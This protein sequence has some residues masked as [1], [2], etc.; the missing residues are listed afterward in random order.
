M[1]Y[2]NLQILPG[3]T[4]PQKRALVRDFTRTLVQRL[5]KRPEHI[6][7]VIQEIAPDSW[8]YA[9]QLT[10]EPARAGKKERS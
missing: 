3:A 2:L 6:H 8:G 4:V 5:G 9:G 7:I 1:P 10:S